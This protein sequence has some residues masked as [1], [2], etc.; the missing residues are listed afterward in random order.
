VTPEGLGVAADAV[1]AALEVAR[2]QHEQ[3]LTTVREAGDVHRR[4]AAAAE[5][6]ADRVR[7]LEATRDEL[8]AAMQP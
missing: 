8:D 1:D 7:S 4:A 6:T 2:Q 3:A 5:A